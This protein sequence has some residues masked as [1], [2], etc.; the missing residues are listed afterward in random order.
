MGFTKG[1]G[2]DDQ[3]QELPESVR[4]RM[5][6]YAGRR[7]LLWWA[8]ETG[9]GRLE[10]VL[11]GDQALCFADPRVDTRHKPVY[12]ISA[13]HLDP[14]SLRRAEVVHRAADPVQHRPAV[15]VDGRDL[16]RVPVDAAFEQ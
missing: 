5:W 7:S 15:G 11:F 14:V 1:P 4:K 2:R 13:Y 3:W 9:S 6:E 8:D 10:A 16:L 12:A